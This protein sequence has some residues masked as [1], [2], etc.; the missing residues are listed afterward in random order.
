M[1][2]ELRDLGGQGAGAQGVLFC[3]VVSTLGCAAIKGGGGP[4]GVDPLR[5]FHSSEVALPENRYRGENRSRHANA[6][7]DALLDRFYT[8]V[9]ERQRMDVLAEVVTT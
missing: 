5:R 4:S 7:L 6:E 1:V 8:T 2:A 9:P 3:M